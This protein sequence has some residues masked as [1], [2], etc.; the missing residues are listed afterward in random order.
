M[1]KLV[2][3]F[4]IFNTYILKIST[5]KRQNGLSDIYELSEMVYTNEQ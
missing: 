2:S 4:T 3:L 5:G 1:I